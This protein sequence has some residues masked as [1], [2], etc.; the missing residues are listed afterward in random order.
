MGKEDI[1]RLHGM[2][3]FGIIKQMQHLCG[4]ASKIVS[5]SGALSP[6][7]F[8]LGWQSSLGEYNHTGNLT[9]MLHLFNTIPIRDP[10]QVTFSIW[11]SHC[12]IEIFLFFYFLQV[13]IQIQYRPKIRQ[14]Y[15]KHI[16]LWPVISIH[17]VCGILRNAY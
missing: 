12:A 15:Y 3:L 4:V 1:T 13:D 7:G 5:P 6:L 8:A 17:T 10:N 9:G 14:I 2:M 11:I 16:T